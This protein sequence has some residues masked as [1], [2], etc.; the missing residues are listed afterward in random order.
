MSDNPVAPHQSANVFMC[1]L[2]FVALCSRWL[3]APALATTGMPNGARAAANSACAWSLSV[4]RNTLQLAAQ[5][6]APHVRTVSLTKQ[7]T[8][9]SSDAPAWRG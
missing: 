4:V 3:I 8:V 7:P 6:P 5:A 2:A 9:C 1:S